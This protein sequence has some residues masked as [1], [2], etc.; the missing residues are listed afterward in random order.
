MT[1]RVFRT[2]GLNDVTGD[3]PRNFGGGTGGGGFLSPKNLEGGGTGG[4]DPDSITLVFD[5]IVTFTD[6]GDPTSEFAT[7][8]RR[9]IRRQFRT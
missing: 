3:W 2:V 9:R 7:L 1:I 5:R 8:R 6:N 4:I